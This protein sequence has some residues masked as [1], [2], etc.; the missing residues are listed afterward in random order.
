MSDYGIDLTGKV[1]LVTGGARGI[2]RAITEALLDAGALAV[3]CGRNDPESLPSAG[4]RTAEFMRCDIRKADQAQAMVAEAAARLGRL[5][6]VVNNAGGSP[7]VPSATSS[8]RLFEAVVALNLLA[9]FYIAQAANTVMQAQ[10]DG[11][12]II[13]IASV[14]GVRPSPGTAAYGSSKAGL[15]NLTRT[16]AIEWG[17]KVRMNALVVGLVDTEA[18]DDHYGSHDAH[19]AI[20]ARIPLGRM[21]VSKDV[22]KAVMLLV[23]PLADYISGAQLAVDGGGEP[24]GYLELAKQ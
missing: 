5:D 13:N 7:E 14:S 19:A 22:A 16:L 24:P 20:A 21:A 3:V 11:G 4:G 6:I 2:G 8:P 23:S 9:P 10:A 17:P 1:A 15:L 18:A 12:Q